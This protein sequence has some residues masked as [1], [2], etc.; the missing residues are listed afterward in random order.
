M[1]D[2]STRGWELVLLEV[3]DAF[4][5]G[6]AAHVDVFDLDEVEGD[7]WDGFWDSAAVVVFCDGAAIAV[8]DLDGE[9]MFEDAVAH[10]GAVF[11]AHSGVL[12]LRFEV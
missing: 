8:G 10:S 1:P 6:F 11:A 7:G 5:E 12:R 4:A 9:V 2:V 3:G